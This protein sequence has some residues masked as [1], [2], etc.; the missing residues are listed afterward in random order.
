MPK[1]ILS[2]ISWAMDASPR[3]AGPGG[4]RI[5]LNVVAK[6]RGGA[7]D[8]RARRHCRFGRRPHRRSAK[9]PGHEDPRHRSREHVRIGRRVGFGALHS[10]SQPQAATHNLWLRPVAASAIR[11]GCGHSRAGWDVCCNGGASPSSYAPTPKR[12]HAAA[13]PGGPLVEREWHGPLGFYCRYAPPASTR[14]G[15]SVEEGGLLYDSNATPKILPDWVDV[16]GQQIGLPQQLQ[17][18]GQQLFA[19]LDQNQPYQFLAY[20][21]DGFESSTAKGRGIEL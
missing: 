17:P 3:S 6:F 1:R 13:S 4:A 18:N 8:Q 15:C 9:R 10:M 12:R 16:G 11:S 20:L 7:E 14:G 21:K 19:R 5:A 2:A